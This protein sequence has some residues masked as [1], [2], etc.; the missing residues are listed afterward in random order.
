MR[1]RGPVDGDPPAV[2]AGPGLAAR[3]A[4]DAADMADPA[5]FRDGED[6]V[7]GRGAAEAVGVKITDPD[8][9]SRRRPEISARYVVTV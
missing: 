5:A 1:E 2:A 3:A 9:I 8:R 6:R 7:A 4:G